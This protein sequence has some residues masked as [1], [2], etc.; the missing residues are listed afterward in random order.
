MAST[1]DLARANFTGAFLPDADAVLIGRAVSVIRAL[2]VSFLALAWLICLLVMCGWVGNIDPLKHLLYN[3]VTG[4]ATVFWFFI[5]TTAAAPTILN[6]PGFS[7]NKIVKISSRTVLCVTLLV[8]LTLWLEHLLGQDW[9]TAVGIF[10]PPG[11]A[12][13]LTLPGATP[14]DVSFCIV[15]TSIIGLALD[16]L[17]SKMPLL[18]QGLS[19]LLAMPSFFLVLACI[20]GVGDAVDVFCAYQGCVRFKYLNYTILF[21]LASAVFLSRPKLGMTSFLAVNSMGGSQVR[22]SIVGAAAMIPVAWILVA[23]KRNEIINEPTA[24]VLGRAC[25]VYRFA[26]QLQDGLSG[27]R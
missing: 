19:L 9:S 13:M 4:F 25:L 23:A 2:S 22:R 17:G 1:D 24:L 18:Y 14:V 5:V 11:D 12:G 16:L 21:C 3:Q 20:F 15:L 10:Q 8:G 27:V 26:I 6:I 7:D